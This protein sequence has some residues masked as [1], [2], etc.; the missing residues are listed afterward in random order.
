MCQWVWE[1]VSVVVGVMPAQAPCSAGSLA[2][3]SR[4]RRGQARGGG[5]L[6]ATLPAAP[7]QARVR[8]PPARRPAD[9]QRQAAVPG[10]RQRPCRRHAEAAVEGAPVPPPPPGGG[11]RGA[12]PPSRTPQPGGVPQPPPHMV[13][14]FLS[15]LEGNVSVGEACAAGAAGGTRARPGDLAAGAAPPSASA[16]GPRG[17]RGRSAG[18]K[19]WGPLSRKSFSFL[20]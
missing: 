17:P 3:P 8:A 1:R 18:G 11:L 6:P 19:V 14:P 9:A 7:A 13:G 5:H 16:S 10:V 12:V 15:A 20:F 2:A 4:R